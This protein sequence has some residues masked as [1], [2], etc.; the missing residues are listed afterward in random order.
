[1]I[2]LIYTLDGA[3]TV[4][5]RDLLMTDGESGSFGQAVSVSEGR[6]TK[7]G[8]TD[9]PFAILIADTEGGTD[10]STEYVPVR[11]DQIFEIDVVGEADINT[12]VGKQAALDSSGMNIDADALEPGKA[13]VLRVDPIKNKAT[14][15]FVA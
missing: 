6:L 2:N 3:A 15:R 12:L 4:I 10:V 7:A 14:V 5:E 1:M 9:A 8:P 11:E 13:L